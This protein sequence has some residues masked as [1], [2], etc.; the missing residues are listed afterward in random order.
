MDS[1]GDT[2]A[3]LESISTSLLAVT[4]TANRLAAED[5][6]F[7]RSLNPSLGSDLDKQNARL[8]ELAQRLLGNAAPGSKAVRPRLKDADAVDDNWRSIVDV[9]DSLLEKADTSLDEF[10]GAVKRLS[11]ARDQGQTTSQ[12]P[13]RISAALKSN[14]LA[15]PQLMF[16][17]RPTNDENAPFQPLLQ[18]KPHASQPLKQSL[19]SYEGQDGLQHMTHPY[20][21]ELETY[22]YPSFVYTRAEPIPHLPFE[23][24]TATLVDTEEAIDEM[25]EELKQ[26]KEIAIDLEHHD[27]RSYIGLVSLMQ[28]STRKRDWIVDTLK[29][30]RRKLSVLNE[31]FADPNILKVLHG[32]HMDIIWLQRDLGL[33][34]VGLFDTYHAS[35]VLG[36]PGGSL[37]FLLKKFIDFDA[38]KQYQTADWRIRPLPQ[39]LF[40]YARSDTHFLLFIYD[41]M[42]NELIDRSSL[43][44][45]NQERDKVHDVLMRSKETASQTYNHPVYDKE[46]GLGSS[47]WYKLLIRTPTQFSKEQFS[48]FRSLHQWRDQVA[49]DQDDSTHFVLS[50]HHLFN[51]SREMP[52]DKSQLFNIV[53]P[54]PQPVK[55]RA[56]EVLEV[57]SGA[58]TSAQDDTREMREV[59]RDIDFYIHGEPI[60]SINEQADATSLPAPQ[61]QQSASAAASIPT[62]GLGTPRAS[63]VSLRAAVSSFWGST[64]NQA[65]NRKVSSLAPRLFVPLPP[66]TAEIFA[67]PA[68]PSA[69]LQNHTSTT[70]IPN[71]TFTPTT[72][73]QEKNEI[74]TL[75]ELS[76]KRKADDQL[77]SDTLA[78]QRDEVSIADDDLATR[79]EEKARRKAERK[80]AKRAR[81]S[82]GD[83]DGEEEAAFDYAAAPS[84]FH[85]ARLEEQQIK[86]G[87]GDREKEGKG[88]GKKEPFSFAKGLGDVQRGLGRRQKDSAGRSMT[89]KD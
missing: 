57:I 32:A 74:F 14:E 26:A 76:N 44:L 43:E 63:L 52:S 71:G 49:R 8:L 15:K 77:Q 9:L 73:A 27:Y 84:V 18:I 12:R 89:F 78:T 37:A 3:L 47:G 69:P 41:N 66:L 55:L 23:S 56:D 85:A 10:S 31:V 42:R 21:P 24:T 46:R 30:W 86:K 67:T 83:D 61:H 20:G 35:R 82:T 70:L 34:V 87:K 72:P 60:P 62:H 19:E 45:P 36:Y 53:Q 1:D 5:F 54:M 6:D 2:K 7:H 28:I 39:E 59:L 11:P 4:R 75:R 48:V 22:E 33:Y 79:R 38:K 68:T 13:S 51:L 25:L 88:R 65:S 17:H 50:N 16:E 64:F 40:D 81:Q 29:P 80:A 58:K